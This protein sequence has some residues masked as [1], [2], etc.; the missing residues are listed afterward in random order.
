MAVRLAG[1]RRRSRG[2]P[3]RAGGDMPGPPGAA[4]RRGRQGLAL[5]GRQRCGLDGPGRH[6]LDRFGIAHGRGRGAPDRRAA[7]ARGGAGAER[8]RGAQGGG[9]GITMSSHLNLIV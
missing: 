5:D 2:L 9:Q 3:P 4:P 1:G 8:Q 7:E 6:G